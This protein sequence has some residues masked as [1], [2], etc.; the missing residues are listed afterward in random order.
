[1][2]PEDCVGVPIPD[3]WYRLVRD[4]V[5]LSLPEGEFEIALVE[6]KEKAKLLAQNLLRSVERMV[7]A[8]ERDDEDALYIGGAEVIETMSALMLAAGASLDKLDQ[9]VEDDAEEFGGYSVG[10]VTKPSESAVQ[11]RRDKIK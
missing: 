11:A 1:V 9:Q 2:S 10:W 5:P 4:K 7:V 8:T 6:G 3:W